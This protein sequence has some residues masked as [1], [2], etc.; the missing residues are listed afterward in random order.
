M[1][2]SCKPCG[3]NGN[4][5]NE[6]EYGTVSTVQYRHN[7]GVFGN[8]IPGMDHTRNVT[9]AAKGDIDHKI[10]STE[11]ATQSDRKEREKDREE[12]Q[13]HISAGVS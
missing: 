6:Q 1:S 9:Q 7:T 2:S 3:N 4:N 11:T 5:N 8:D 12:D 10:S 13:K